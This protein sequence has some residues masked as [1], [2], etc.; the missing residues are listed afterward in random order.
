M[1]CRT[2]RSSR[3]SRK[4]SGN[5]RDPRNLPDL[6]INGDSKPD[7]SSHPAGA[8]VNRG[9]MRVAPWRT[10]VK[11]PLAF[12]LSNTPF[13]ASL[14]R[15]QS[16]NS[17]G[18]W[19]GDSAFIR[20]PEKRRRSGKSQHAG[21]LLLLFCFTSVLFLYSN[22]G[23]ALPMILTCNEYL[24]GSKLKI[25]VGIR[26]SSSSGIGKVFPPVPA[27]EAWVIGRTYDRLLN[28]GREAPKRRGIIRNAPGFV[29]STLARHVVAH[30]IHER[31]PYS[32]VRVASG[33]TLFSIERCSSPTSD[34]QARCRRTA[35]EALVRGR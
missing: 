30:A 19:S 34:Q 22:A 33:P 8:V 16:L 2:P 29:V 9:R 21:F 12:A 26:A 6:T 5:S 1:W 27:K 14:F 15:R 3:A 18:S 11:I 28:T 24:P 25:R 35:K 10:V 4:L 17:Q 31:R 13:P 23:L 20:F 32:S 7:R